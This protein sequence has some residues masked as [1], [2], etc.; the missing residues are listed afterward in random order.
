ML[1]RFPVDFLKVGGRNNTFEAVMIFTIVVDVAVTAGN[2]NDS[3]PYL[4]RIEYMREQLGLDIR[5]AC[6][7]SAYGTSLICR[8]MEDM[9]ISLHTHGATG[10]VTYKVELTRGDFAYNP[11]RDCFICPMG[12]KLPLKSPEREKHNIC[13]VC[14]ASRRDCR[15]CPLLEK[16]VS[17][18]HRSRTI[19]TNIFEE[20]VKR[21]RQMDNRPE[22]KHILNLRQ[23]WCE[24]SFAAQK[25]EHNLRR[26]F[27]RGLEAAEDHCLLSATALNLKRMVKCL[28]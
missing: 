18:S 27:R 2:T 6:A 11:E 17:D 1:L 24:G 9:G 4:S 8:A 12:K 21:Q 25:W 28:G 10:G 15:T 26:L 16:C 23:I 7:D 22:H 14:R 20:S 19:R 5:T 3:E 13:R